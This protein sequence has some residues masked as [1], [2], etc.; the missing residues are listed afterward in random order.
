MRTLTDKIRVVGGEGRPKQ[1]EA[2]EPIV[3]TS[4]PMRKVLRIISRIAAADE[5]VLI[6]GESGTGKEMVAHLIWAQ[7]R[8]ADRDFV[9]INC[10]AIPEGLLESELF[11]HE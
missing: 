7:S 5:T 1:G 9:V 8:R 11:G 6:T 2:A 3:G 4:P 10:A